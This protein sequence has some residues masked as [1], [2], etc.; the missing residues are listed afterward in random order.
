[1]YI[2]G[3]IKVVTQPSIR[4]TISFCITKL[5]KT[6]NV[7]SIVNLFTASILI[8]LYYPICY[9]RTTW[10]YANN[11]ANSC[12]PDIYSICW[13]S[14]FGLLLNWNQ[15]LTYTRFAVIIWNQA[16]WSNG[17][18]IGRE[19]STIDV[20]TTNR[21]LASSL[22]L[23]VFTMSIIFGV[24]NRCVIIKWP[25]ELNARNTAFFF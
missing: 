16:Q 24:S 22:K 20:Q 17:A 23:V 5:V 18:I 15:A 9:S 21:L 6:V 13:L 8:T 11:A 10:N 19:Q 3:N 7:L 1:M 25:T 14:A 4:P 2:C 12:D